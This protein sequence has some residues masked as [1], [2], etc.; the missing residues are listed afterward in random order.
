MKWRSEKC[1]LYEKASWPARARDKIQPFLETDTRHY[2]IAIECL[3]AKVEGSGPVD[4]QGEF[5]A[6][7][8]S[9]FF[10]A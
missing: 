10:P 7:V 8:R 1:R 2:T 6:P 5:F 4:N 9:E 3:I